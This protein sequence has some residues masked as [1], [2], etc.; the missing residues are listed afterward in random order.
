MGKEI[1]SIEDVKVIL[2][3]FLTKQTIDYDT[4]TIYLK[5]AKEAYIKV[6]DQDG[7]KRVWVLETILSIQQ[8]YLTIFNLLKKR[9]YYKAWQELENCEIMITS[10]AQHYDYKSNASVYFIDEYVKKYQSLYP[11]KLFLSYEIIQDEVLCSICK[12]KITPRNFCGHIKGEIYNGEQCCRIV[13]KATLLA[14]SVVQNPVHK[15]AVLFPGEINNDPYRYNLLD[16]LIP[17]LNTPFSQWQLT[18]TKKEYPISKFHNVRQ[19]NL[20]PCGSKKKFKNC[21]IN[22]TIAIV[23]HCF[24]FDEVPYDSFKDEQI[25]TF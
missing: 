1:T 7:A 11:Y 16:H 20:C 17:R 18:V 14:I 23:H 10:L 9:E 24:T 25:L 19:N 6:F 4:L 2:D 15:Y 22:K 5:N 12:K 13:N 3:S 8:C 21:C